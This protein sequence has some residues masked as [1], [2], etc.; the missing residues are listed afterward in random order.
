MNRFKRI[1]IKFL[2]FLLS[3]LEEENTNKN[4][5]SKDEEVSDIGGGGIKNPKP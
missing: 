4:I 3:L 2:S 1:A 5:Y